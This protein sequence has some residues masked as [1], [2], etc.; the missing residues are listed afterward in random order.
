M[1]KTV[2]TSI[3]TSVFDHSKVAA[4]RRDTI[5]GSIC[6]GYK[7]LFSYHPSGVYAWVKMLE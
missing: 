1:P 3:G 4:N 7:I 2:I 6:I 5:R